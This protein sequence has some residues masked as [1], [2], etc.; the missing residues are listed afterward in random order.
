MCGFGCKEGGWVGWP[1]SVTVDAPK[2]ASVGLVCMLQS[3]KEKIDCCTSHL[4]RDYCI[5]HLCILFAVVGKCCKRV[6]PD[7][8]WVQFEWYAFDEWCCM[9]WGDPVQSTGHYSPRTNWLIVCRLP[10]D[11]QKK[12]LELQKATNEYHSC[13]QGNLI[14]KQGKVF[15]RKASSCR[16][17][18]CMTVEPSSYGR[19]L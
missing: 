2:S 18:L 5:S 4:F 15:K 7:W 8:H 17:Y 6:K 14:L 9:S 3:T 12:K 10:Q 1:L 16:F 11:E 13:V 19:L